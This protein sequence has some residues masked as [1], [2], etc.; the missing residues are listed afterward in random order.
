MS[1]SSAS[2]RKQATSPLPNASRRFSD[3]SPLPPERREPGG[4][5]FFPP[6]SPEASGQIWR[7]VPGANWR[8]PLG[9]D[10]NIE[11]REKYPVVQVCWDDAVA[12]A[13]W[14]GKR[15]PTEAEWEYAARGG[16]CISR[17][18]GAGNSSQAASGWP[19]SGRESFRSRTR[20]KTVSRVSP[21]W[22]NFAPTSWPPRHGRKC[23]G[24]VR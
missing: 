20:A 14:A 17:M 9:P 16:K 23:L 19:M 7:Y 5:V 15:L 1:N 24:M 18:S 21:P 12:F 8:H 22:G 10:S 4:W 13:H 6:K 2:S 11:G 3:M